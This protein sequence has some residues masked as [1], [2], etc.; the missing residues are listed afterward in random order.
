MGSA[1]CAFCSDESNL[2]QTSS[3]T[4]PMTGRNVATQSTVSSSTIEP[5]PEQKQAPSKSSSGPIES[6]HEAIADGNH[7]MMI[8]LVNEHSNLDLVNGIH[9]NQTALHVA[10]RYKQYKIIKYLFSQQA[11][12]NTPNE[13]TK[14]SPLHYA[15]QDGDIKCVKLLSRNGG[16]A[17]ATPYR[18]RISRKAVSHQMLTKACIIALDTI[19]LLEMNSVH[20]A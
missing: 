14:D 18:G 12:T 4:G 6:L 15:V 11:L 10:V 7:K 20:D 5:E 16:N 2:N 1:N 19:V 8:K 13:R 9:N 17:F 3:D